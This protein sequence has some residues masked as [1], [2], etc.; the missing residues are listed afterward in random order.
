VAGYAMQREHR[1][2]AIVENE[3]LNIF[4]L[5]LIPFLSSPIASPSYR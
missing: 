1:K 3:G 4:I 2:G 5:T